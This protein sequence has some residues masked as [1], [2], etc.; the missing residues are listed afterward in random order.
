MKTNK[1]Q[2]IMQGVQGEIQNPVN[3]DYVIGYDGRISTL[4]NCG[5]INYN[6]HVGDSA[7][8]WEG[9]EI[10]PGVS[11][12][13]SNKEYSLALRRLACIG[14]KAQVITGKAEDAIGVVTGF[15]NGE[16]SGH[17][18]IDFSEED[19]NKMK[20]GDQILIK[21]YGQG[22]KLEDYPKVKVFNI[23]PDLLD[24]IDIEE[25]NKKL[26]VPVKAII[27]AHLNGS[28]SAAGETTDAEVHIS[29]SN[30]KEIIKYGLEKL[31][32]GD[33]VL[34][35]GADNCYGHGYLKSACSIGIVVHGSST[36][37]SRGPGVVI[38]MT[39]QEEIFEGKISL[40]A[41]IANM[42]EK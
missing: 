25:K 39:C 31:C 10:E 23:D 24:K 8:E 29:T 12:Y 28:A 1:K 7:F 6:V 4:P 38:I 26:I 41:N 9:E 35:E 42:I 13:N 30:E 33:L 37:A 2:L 34:L 19:M 32:I 22:L 17:V 14:N 27:P 15:Q 18:M 36:M 11:I 40:D 21:A 5:S 20:I 3:D 16:N